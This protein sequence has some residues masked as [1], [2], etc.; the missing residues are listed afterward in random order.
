MYKIIKLLVDNDTVNEKLFYDYQ[1]IYTEEAFR[2]AEF[3]KLNKKE[4]NPNYVSDFIHPLTKYEILNESKRILKLKKIKKNYKLNPIWR[5]SSYRFNGDSIILYY[6]RYYKVTR[7]N[8]K[9]RVR[10]YQKQQ[11][12]T[13]KMHSVKLKKSGDYWYIYMT[14]SMRK[15]KREKTNIVMGVD[16]GIRVPAVCVTS[17]GK[18][19][20][21]GNG[22]YIRFVERNI[23][24]KYR[25]LDKTKNKEAIKKMN[26]KLAN[27]KRH[28]DHQ[29]SKEIIDFA[30]QHDVYIIK[31]EKLT[32]I[33]NHMIKKK[34]K[35][36]NMWSYNRLQNFLI[37]KA[38]EKGIVIQHVSPRFTSKQCPNCRKINDPKGRE[39]KCKCGYRG[40][41]DIV[42][43]YNIMKSTTVI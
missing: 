11:L 7:I 9:L 21:I 2:A 15:E 25:K 6:G 26:H 27:I 10:E 38:E 33:Q 24:A 40:H 23:K 19:K 39:Y 16:L 28:L 41:R 4:L 42:G 29:Y 31:L 35:R 14:V 12:H 34:M 8:L 20:F 22:R 5:S 32:G 36:E 30:K 13:C 43:A 37:Q 1:K 17:T 18:V 3:Y